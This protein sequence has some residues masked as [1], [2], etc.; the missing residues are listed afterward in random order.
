LPTEEGFGGEGHAVVERADRFST[1]GAQRLLVVH[2]Q[3]SAV[4]TGEA[5]QRDA[6]D[7][8][9]VRRELGGVGE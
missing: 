3:R 6:A 8:D 7:G 4:G 9:V 2:E 1:S 5:A